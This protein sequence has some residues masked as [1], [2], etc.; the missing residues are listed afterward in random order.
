MSQKECGSHG[1]E[2][3]KKEKREKERR[4]KKRERE[5][6]DVVN[7]GAVWCREIGKVLKC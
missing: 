7:S 3:E 4:K 1:C 2:R 5:R 6:W